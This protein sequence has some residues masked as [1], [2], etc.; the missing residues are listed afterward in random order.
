[1]KQYLSVFLS[2]WLA[3]ATAVLA[4]QPFILKDPG[5]VT[6]I[7]ASPN[8]ASL[9]TYGN[10]QLNMYTGIPSIS[11]PL[12]VVQSGDLSMPVSLSYNAG[13]VKVEE[14]A[15]WTG[16]AWSLNA[17]GVITRSARG[18]PD[19][20]AGNYAANVQKLNDGA[21]P[22]D[23]R[24]TLLQ[25]I[26][27]GLADAEA[28]I[29][30][31]NF[32]GYSG[33][34]FI[35]EDGVT[36]YTMPHQ[37]LKIYSQDG[38]KRWVVLAPDGVQYVFGKTMDGTR[39]ARDVNTPTSRCMDRSSSQLGGPSGSPSVTAW[40]LLEV[41]SPN[42]NTIRFHY[43]EYRQAFSTLVTETN[44]YSD[45]SAN[46]PNLP[47]DC[48]PCKD[49]NTICFNINTVTVQRLKT[50]HFKNGRIELTPS[51]LYRA[52]LYG[53]KSL[54]SIA[55]YNSSAPGTVV[56]RFDFTYGYFKST[57]A[58]QPVEHSLLQGREE[59]TYS[60]FSP[61]RL[62]LLTVT[63]AGRDGVKKPP[64]R[65]EYNEKYPL[66]DRLKI[67]TGV[68]P[69]P[70]EAFAQDHWG[71]Y[72][73]RSYNK[74]LTTPYVRNNSNPAYRPKEY[75]GADRRTVEAYAKSGTLVQIT[76][77]TGATTDFEFESNSVP[78][79]Q[80]TQVPGGAMEN[81]LV[82][83]EGA[84]ETLIM[85]NFSMS[86]N[87]S[88]VTRAFTV[89]SLYTNSSGQSGAWASISA[90]ESGYALCQY[91]GNACTGCTQEQANLNNTWTITNFTTGQVWKDTQG[92]D[93]F[94]PNGSY[95][96]V[97][98]RVSTTYSCKS[99]FILSIGFS[100]YFVGDQ[101]QPT[102]NVYVGG[103]RVKRTVDFDGINH[104]ND[105]IRTYKYHSLANP[106]QSSGVLVNYPVYGWTGY[107]EA[108]TCSHT[109]PLGTTFYQYSCSFS[110][111]NSGSNYPLATTQGGCVGYA[112]VTVETGPDQNNGKTEYTFTT[113]A[114]Y[115]DG[116]S[117]TGFPFA[118][119]TNVDWRRGINRQAKTYSFQG[120]AHVKV[121]EKSS[122][123]TT[124]LGSQNPF[125]KSATGVKVGVVT[126]KVGTNEA[127]N[128]GFSVQSYPTQSEWHYLVSET[129][130]Q[131]DQN[132]PANTK[133]IETG[134]SYEY[135]Q[136][137]LQPSKI[138]TTDSNG[139]QILQ[140]FK[141]PLNYDVSS[142]TTSSK[143]EALA[144][145]NLQNKNVITVPVE[146]YV[147]RQKPDG[148]NKR[149]V[150]A[151]L[152]VFKAAQPLPE[153]IYSLESADNVT[154][155]TPS[156]ISSGSLSKD[157][158]Y[159]PKVVFQQYT[160]D[161]NILQQAKADDVPTSYIW[162]YGGTLPIAEA[163]NAE[164]DQIFYTSFE[165]NGT[166]AD[167]TGKAKTGD[168]YFVNPGTYT[169]SFTPP[170]A[171]TY[172]LSYWYWSN[173]KWNY[174]ERPFTSSITEGERLD[175]IRVYPKGAQMTTFS[176][177]PL[178]GITS[179]TDAAN[180]TTYYEYDTLGR[181]KLVK[182]QDRRTVKN[183]VYYYKK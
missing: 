139:D 67:T 135:D 125:Y 6:A 87:V 49:R 32:G 14:I 5:L 147:Q 101:A 45:G 162:G 163:K 35:G 47:G 108:V 16:L 31:F 105:V 84:G 140:L 124:L 169:L 97:L 121:E 9:G 152:T 115:P 99:N 52:D 75:D 19:G 88:Q 157:G 15:S 119:A 154:G 168:R 66:P 96:A 27:A 166:V 26:S 122:N 90:V 183:Y 82:T 146:K 4:Q 132:D 85:D 72:N 158:R 7:P 13:G 21:Y 11:I 60:D 48:P 167:A 176:H 149:T 144:I 159:Q 153:I 126:R 12:Y 106:G 89:N 59:F 38:M 22:A 112:N 178:T 28:D 131:Y 104:Q 80:L 138:T 51:T 93:I 113:A 50:I 111:R 33:K 130:K 173:G 63:E 116:R 57:Y 179:H 1:M 148:T 3:S 10:T 137:S 177:D 94:L 136:N 81:G 120:N 172:I 161:G 110:I 133:S 17:G 23:L 58:P 20:Q 65:F 83:N 46:Y 41:T 39:E 182:D 109:T 100:E 145:K 170:D 86:N 34:F 37:K 56:K 123:P 180:V 175:E 128:D 44:Y 151:Q 107:R 117:S 103:L 165:E 8:A 30:F 68:N 40:H 73:G 53:D 174:R 25:N 102:D 69:Q 156:A 150:S 43:E 171:S 95:Q 54:S 142:V 29:F 91:P 62:K 36:C 74:K 134:V 64:H 164:T 79:G 76:Y 77:P 129:A 18:V 61:Y 127:G 2:L 78:L 42:N 71:Y 118:P 92:K 143:P 55:V 114:D 70:S 98:R 160:S 24:Q 141:Y 181:V 155:F